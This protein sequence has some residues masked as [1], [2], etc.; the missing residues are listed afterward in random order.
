MLKVVEMSRQ[1]QGM[2][3]LEVLGEVLKD[4]RL[5]LCLI[6]SVKDFTRMVMV[7]GTGFSM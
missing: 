7:A 3:T 6:R 4:K 2:K 5:S 1:M